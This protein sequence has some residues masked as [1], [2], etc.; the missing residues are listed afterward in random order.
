MGARKKK[1]V[2]PRL[3]AERLTCSGTGKDVMRWHSDYET[4][5][6]QHCLGY[7]ACLHWAARTIGM[8]AS[9]AEFLQTEA[10]E[11]VWVL[12]RAFEFQFMKIT[13]QKGMWL[14]IQDTTATSRES[15]STP[16]CQCAQ[17]KSWAG[18]SPRSIPANI[19]LVKPTTSQTIFARDHQPGTGRAT[20]API[21][22]S[23]ILKLNAR[24]AHAR[25]ARE[26]YSR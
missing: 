19:K 20:N 23:T 5:R 2:A 26:P 18:G 7:P 4:C 14:E 3:G 12:G 11:R 13:S 24:K 6:R 17:T 10:A 9:Q 16:S 1:M 15:A 22:E 25:V 21:H 8:M